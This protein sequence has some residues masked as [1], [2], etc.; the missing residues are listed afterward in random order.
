MSE[1]RLGRIES[2]VDGLVESMITLVRVEEKQK[3]TDN[4]LERYGFRLDDLER[5]VETIEK[6]MP[7]LDVLLKVTGK[8]WFI[9]ITAI[10]LSV[11]GV[12]L[13]P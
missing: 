12:V 8:V 10:T 13:I 7:L 9:I 5:R 6:V 1:E 4:V 3:G 11:L 2:K